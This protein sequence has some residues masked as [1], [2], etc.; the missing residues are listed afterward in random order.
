MTPSADRPVLGLEEA[1]KRLAGL[2]D[3]P[4]G[5]AWEK[6]ALETLLWLAERARMALRYGGSCSECDIAEGC[7]EYS[8][9]TCVEPTNEL[10]DWLGQS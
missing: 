4:A 7:D 9:Q 3:Y 5:R 8:V 1:K 10:S 2:G 6:L